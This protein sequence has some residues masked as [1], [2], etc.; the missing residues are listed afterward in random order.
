MYKKKCSSCGLGKCKSKPQWEVSHFI[1]TRMAKIKTTDNNKC[2]QVCGEIGLW[3]GVT[4]LENSVAVPQNVKYRVTIWQSNSILSYIPVFVCKGRHNKI[5]QTGWHKE[6]KFVFSLFWKFKTKV[7]AGLDSPET[8]V[9]SLQMAALLLPLHM[10]VPLC[11]HTPLISFSYKDT[12]Q[13]GL[14]PTLKASF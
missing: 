3:N 11:T 13:I 6:Q 12:G 4:T 2:W 1:L 8:S 7:P 10:V 14:G 9:T 5:L